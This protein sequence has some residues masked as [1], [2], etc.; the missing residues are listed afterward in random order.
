LPA[1]PLELED[2]ES[3]SLEEVPLLLFFDL[4]ADGSLEEALLSVDFEDELPVSL[5]DVLGADD[6]EL[7]VDEELDELLGLLLEPDVPLFIEDEPLVPEVDAAPL[8]C[9][10]EPDDGLCVLP[11]LYVDEVVVPSVLGAFLLLCMSPSASA[12]PLASTMMDEKKTGASLRMGPPGRWLVKACRKARCKQR[13]IGTAARARGERRAARTFYETAPK[14]MPTLRRA[15]M[16]RAGLRLP[17]ADPDA[18]AIAPAPAVVRPSRRPVH[19]AAPL[20]DPMARDPE[21]PAVAPLP[22]SRRPHPPDARGGDHLVSH[23]RRCHVHEEL[24]VRTR[25]GGDGGKAHECRGDASDDQ[26]AHG[27]TSCPEKRTSL[28]AG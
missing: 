9:D 3:L 13:A 6:E 10:E 26:F 24:H 25:R 21:V 11:L 15:G 12:E 18:R 22:E 23:R 20:A 8:Y 27:V 14:K 28:R 5:D 1:D 4:L 17:G 7:G 2:W 19:V 16:G